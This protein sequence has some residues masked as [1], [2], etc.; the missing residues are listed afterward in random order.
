MENSIIVNFKE[1]KDIFLDEK[2]AIEFF[3]AENVLPK[4]KTCASCRTLVVIVKSTRSSA[5]YIYKCRNVHCR[6][7][8]SII[9]TLNFSFQKISIKKLRMASYFYSMKLQCYQVLIITSISENTYVKLKRIFLSRLKEKYRNVGL[10]G[11]DNISIQVDETACCRRT[12]IFNPTSE[13]AYIRDTIWL[14]ILYGNRL[15]R[16]G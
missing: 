7:T 8:T 12:T 4:Y 11:G 14:L 6:K 9:K 2:C 1:H 3:I 13:A 15:V 16:L 10:L 5:E